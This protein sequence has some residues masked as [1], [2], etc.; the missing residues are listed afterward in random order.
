LPGRQIFR[1]SAVLRNDSVGPSIQAMEA[2]AC[3]RV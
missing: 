3:I 1:G 2:A